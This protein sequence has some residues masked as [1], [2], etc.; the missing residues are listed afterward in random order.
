[1]YWA[2]VSSRF[3]I[4]G[5]PGFGWASKVFRD[6]LLDREF[7]CVPVI[8]PGTANLDDVPAFLAHNF[9]NRKPI[10]C[11][12]S[13]GM[14][15]LDVIAAPLVLK[16]SPEMLKA[17]E[18]AVHDHGTGFFV[19]GWFGNDSPG[20]TPQLLALHGIS[21]GQ[22]GWN[23]KDQN[24]KVLIEHPILKGS[25]LHIGDVLKM[26]PNGAYGVSNAIPIIGVDVKVISPVGPNTVPDQPDFQFAPLAI[27]G[28]GKGRV[29]TFS[30]LGHSNDSRTQA[31]I[32]L[33]TV[34]SVKW[35]A[36]HL[37]EKEEG[38]L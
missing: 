29:V 2:G 36:G 25:A 33:I 17:V 22:W 31:A 18:S 8:D 13:A 11:T 10:E 9:P 20:F 34:R 37:D 38:G 12:D 5:R 1:V 14:A 19:R 32:R 3:D 16:V 28:Y 35:L 27:S 23:G 30:V 4:T 26:E 15:E 7:D 21:N 6:G 24:C